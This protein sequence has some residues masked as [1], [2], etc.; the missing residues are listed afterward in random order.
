M[1]EEKITVY[2]GATASEKP[3]SEVKKIIS[4]ALQVENFSV[5]MGAGCSSYWMKKEDDESE[6]EYG[7]STMAGLFSDFMKENPGFEILGEDISEKVN[8]NLEELMDFMNAINQVN[9]I[10]EVDPEIE[11]K[12][13]TVKKFITVKIN[14][15]MNCDEL[16]SVYKRFYLKT[17]SSNRKTPINII[18]TNYDM[19]NERA[20][21]ELNF[22]YNNGF[23]G[24]YKRVF[25]PNTYRFMYVDNMNLQKDIWTRVDHFYNL[26]KIHGSLSWKKKNEQ[27]LEVP[28]DKYE[29][30]ELPNV[31]IYPTPLKDRSTLMVPYT[32][33]MRNFQDNLMK[34]NTVLLTLGYSFGDDHINRI[35]LNNLSIPSFR[36]I[37]LGETHSKDEFGKNK[38]TN[39]GKLTE[40]D[41]SRITII[42]SEDKIHYFKNFVDKLMPA[43]PN[44]EEEQKMTEK[45]NEVLLNLS[46]KGDANE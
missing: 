2:Q 28:S 4:Q 46:S 31:M 39:I 30:E 38:L 12:I 10:K 14:E 18:T 25:N 42:N 41:D 43:I 44:E 9:N 16:A 21:D 24:A 36:L 15:G 23:T 11:N 5:L 6:K 35:I 22:V 7:I 26:Y 20:L 33:L 37:V 27:I 17:I 13:L 34:K 8:K 1:S 32:D 19:Y 3:I 29:D 45:I 40:M